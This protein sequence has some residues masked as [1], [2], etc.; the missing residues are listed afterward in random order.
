MSDDKKL[1]LERRNRFVRA[2][3]TGAGLALTACDPGSRTCESVRHTFPDPVARGVNCA[4]APM[5][6][7]SVALVD[8]GAPKPCL[9]PVVRPPSD[10]GDGG[11]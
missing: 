1:I 10:A 7:L 2:A 8:A 3:L 4:P 11:D 5:P 6:C 9:S